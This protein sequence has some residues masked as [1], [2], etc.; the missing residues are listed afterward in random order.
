M[1]TKEE[2]KKILVLE[3]TE[4]EFEVLRQL[5][6]ENLKHNQETLIDFKYMPIPECKCGK[7]DKDDFAK[8]H[9]NFIRGMENGVKTLISL[10]EKI[11]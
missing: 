1:E 6:V 10:A 3:L 5:V 9:A 11:Q 8:E 2:I 4:K 7:C